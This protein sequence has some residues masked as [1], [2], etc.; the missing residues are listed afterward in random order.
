MP[1]L[2]DTGVIYALADRHDSW[3]ERVRA[4]LETVIEPLVVPVTVIP[5]ATYLIQTKLGSQ[6]ERAF[7]RSLTTHELDI[8]PL[9]QTDVKRA[10]AVLEKYPEIGF[11]DAS[12]V[13]MAERL[14][15]QRIATTDRRHFGPIRPTHIKA[16]ELVP[17]VQTLSKLPR[18]D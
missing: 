5:E 14:K 9:Q 16:F 7:V 12:V 8:E 2:L 18:S 13:A 10:A 4:Y 15:L 17:W 11:V 3:H 6:A 1:L